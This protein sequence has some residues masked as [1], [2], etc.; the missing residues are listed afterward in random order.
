M[1]FYQISNFKFPSLNIL[2]NISEKCT[3]FDT[4]LISANDELVDLF[5]KDKI[6][7]ND[8]SFDVLI[9]NHVLEHVNDDK[10]VLT[11]FY[12]VLKP[13]GWGIFQVPIDTNNQN[14][15]EDPNIIDPKERE[16]LYWQADHVR[17]FGLDYG[18]RLEKAGFKVT[19]SDFINNLDPALVERY[20]LPKG[21]IIYFCEKK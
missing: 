12:R 13:G 17:L 15:E 16:R 20:S 10:K 3:L 14:T 18:K 6:Q 5:L 9:C 2:K 11:E 1:N 8:N 19:E 21:E 7:F 4:V